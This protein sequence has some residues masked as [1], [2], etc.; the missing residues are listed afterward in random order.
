MRYKNVG[1]TI[2][3]DLKV[4]E[5]LCTFRQAHNEYLLTIHLR[6]QDYLYLVDTQTIT[7]RSSD[8][9]RDIADMISYAVDTHYFDKYIEDFFGQIGGG[10]DT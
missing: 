10:R 6:A 1:Q 2:S 4:C 8:I 3:F 7:R 5:V 9:R